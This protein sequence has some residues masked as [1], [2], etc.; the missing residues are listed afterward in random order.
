MGSHEWRAE[1][2]LFVELAQKRQIVDPE[3]WADDYLRE[4]HDAADLRALGRCRECRASIVLRQSGRCV[5]SHPCGHYR[6]QGDLKIMQ[7]F[8]DTRRRN[9]T[10]ERRA[11]LLQ[12]VQPPPGITS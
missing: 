12:L 10:A 7:T 3:Q 6:A 1:R 2:A 4:H 11:S 5:V 8:L 9:L